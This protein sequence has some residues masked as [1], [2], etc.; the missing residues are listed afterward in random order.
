MTNQYPGENRRAP[1]DFVML[2]SHL[3]S[4]IV[5][6]LKETAKD[7]EFSKAFWRKGF[8]ELS[9]HSAAGASEWIGKKL[10]VWAA[11]AIAASLLV[12]LVR[13]GAIK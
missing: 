7:P 11:T 3:T 9:S 1:I 5:G 12:W 10:L 8:E 4:A 2:Q 6:A 13:T